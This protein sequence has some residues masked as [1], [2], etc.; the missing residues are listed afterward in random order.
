MAHSCRAARVVA[1]VV[2]DELIAAGAQAVILTGSWARGEGTPESDLDLHALGNGP[3]YRLSRRD[4]YLLSVTWETAESV[5]AAFHGPLA[6][7]GAVGGWR[8]AV[9]LADPEGLAAALQRGRR[10]GGGR[11]SGRP[12]ATE[13]WPSGSPAWRRR[14]TNS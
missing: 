7:G 12:V 9:I 6:A 11:R 3:P 14:S 5:R 4:G 13:R 10:P 8:Q 2:A 1:D